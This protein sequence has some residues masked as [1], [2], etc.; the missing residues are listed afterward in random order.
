LGSRSL[1]GRHDRRAR[2]Q[3]AIAKYRDHLPLYRQFEIYARD[4]V[5]LVR[6]LLRWIGKSV[7]PLQSMAEKIG[8]HVMAETVIRADDTPVKVPA[9]CWH[10][11]NGPLPY[12]RDR[13][14]SMGGHH[15]R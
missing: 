2:R 10:D 6:S 4:G 3:L 12:L 14:R 5:E 8:E 13:R 1:H 9:A 11:Q 7:W 15:R